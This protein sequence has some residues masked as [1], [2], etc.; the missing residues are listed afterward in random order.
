MSFHPCFSVRLFKNTDL[1]NHQNEHE[2]L[3][4]TLCDR[5]LPYANTFVIIKRR[6]LVFIFCFERILRILYVYAPI[7]NLTRS[8]IYIHG[9]YLF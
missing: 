4:S 9:I 3:L 6:I 7:P 8:I 5:H 2:D 1:K